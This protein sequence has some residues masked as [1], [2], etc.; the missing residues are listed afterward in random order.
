MDTL[1]QLLTVPVTAARVQDLDGAMPMLTRVCHTC[2]CIAPC[3]CIALVWADSA[4]AGRLAGWAAEKLALELTIVKRTD[5][6]QG[7]VVLTRRRVVERT[8]G[9]PE[10]GGADH[11]R[12]PNLRGHLAPAQGADPSGAQGGGRPGPDWPGRLHRAATRN[13]DR[14]RHYVPAHRGEHLSSLEGQGRSSISWSEPVQAVRGAFGAE[15]GVGGG[16]GVRVVRV[17]AS[18]AHEQAGGGAA[19]VDRA[20]VADVHGQV[21]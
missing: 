18:G 21:G 9:Q 19:E 11:A 1:G 16:A 2:L 6:T 17:D 15:D 7:F 4:Y 14:Q 5:D 13:A 8:L 10:E 12:A 3:L 20:E